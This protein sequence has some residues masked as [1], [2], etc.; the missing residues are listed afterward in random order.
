MTNFIG[1]VLEMQK[2]DDLFLKKFE[3]DHYILPRTFTNL[4]M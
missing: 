1:N 4:G 3:S 2:G